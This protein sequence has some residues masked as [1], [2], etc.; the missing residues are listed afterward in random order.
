MSAALLEAH[1]IVKYYG[2]VQAL[3]GA[4]FSVDAGEVEVEEDRRDRPDTE[5]L[6]GLLPG[7]GV[8]EAIAVP[9]EERPKHVGDGVVVLDEQHRLRARGHGSS[10]ALQM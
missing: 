6:H 5:T 2:H 9:L 10:L 8:K 7:E 3:R 1:G 4:D